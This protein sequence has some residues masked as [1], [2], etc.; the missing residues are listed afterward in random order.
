METVPAHSY[1]L[2]LGEA[3]TMVHVA[4]F[5]LDMYGCLNEAML[6]SASRVFSKMFPQVSLISSSSDCQHS[7]Q[8]L[9]NT[10]RSKNGTL[11][12]CVIAWKLH[13]PTLLIKLSPAT[14]VIEMNHFHLCATMYPVVTGGSW[15]AGW[16]RLSAWSCNNFVCIVPHAL[17]MLYKYIRCASSSIAWLCMAT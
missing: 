2:L 12:Q 10:E 5:A 6:W 3:R 14:S 16:G 8:G 9:Q 1:V 17:C 13:T 15:Q 11:W 7:L 4:C